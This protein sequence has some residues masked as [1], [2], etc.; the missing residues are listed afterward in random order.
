M[1]YSSIEKRREYDR[2]WKA[3]Q[4]STEEGRKKN[5]VAQANYRKK[6][7][8][9]H[10]ERARSYAKDNR[11]LINKRL[12][13]KYKNDPIWRMQC[14]L[15]SRMKDGWNS[16]N[17]V[18]KGAYSDFLGCSFDELKIHIESRF[19]PGMTWENQG[20]WH[21]DHV[22]PLSFYAKLK[23]DGTEDFFDMYLDDAFHY[24]NLRP[25][26]GK[27]NMSRGNRW[28]VPMVGVST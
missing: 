1:A 23:K 4:R 24:L 27:E 8:E 26:W 6:Y 9:L 2:K 17:L 18:S 11:E 16:S 10:R 15:R 3:K 5:L 12:R 19:K 25:E 14:L 7:I 22:V 13:E 20:E 28:I 21:I